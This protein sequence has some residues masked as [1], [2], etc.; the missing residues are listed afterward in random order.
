M[1]NHVLKADTAAWKLALSKL[2]A[3]KAE[4]AAMKIPR[5]RDI[6][7]DKWETYFVA[8]SALLTLPAPDLNAVIEKLMLLWNEDLASGAPESLQRCRVIGDIRRIGAFS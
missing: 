2:R 5:D 4:C 3:A 7:N 8:E 6:Q 1:T